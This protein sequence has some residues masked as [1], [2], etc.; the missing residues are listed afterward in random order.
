MYAEQLLDKMEKS[1]N[2]YKEMGI[3]EPELKVNKTI[4]KINLSKEY[5]KYLDDNNI[6]DDGCSHL[7]KA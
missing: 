2:K 3:K 5:S 6:G 1:W 4:K 7:S